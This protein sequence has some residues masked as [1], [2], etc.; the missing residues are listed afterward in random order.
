MRRAALCG[1][2]T[3]N[4]ADGGEA[5]ARPRRTQNNEAARTRQSREASSEAAAAWPGSS[6]GE[7]YGGR[8]TGRKGRKGGEGEVIGLDARRGEMMDHQKLRSPGHCVKG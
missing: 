1:A 3:L 5:G 8:M 2:R 6:L 4:G 7:F